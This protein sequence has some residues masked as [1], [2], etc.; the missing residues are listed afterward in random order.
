VRRHA[1]N[2]AAVVP[3]LEASTVMSWDARGG[4]AMRDAKFVTHAGAKVEV[5]EGMVE[6]VEGM[7]EVVV[8]SVR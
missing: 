6:V 4:I 2:V 5:V 1:V 8:D 7:V 3:Y